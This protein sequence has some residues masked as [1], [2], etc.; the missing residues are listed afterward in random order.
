MWMVALLV[1]SDS[2]F[3]VSQGTLPTSGFRVTVDK[4]VLEFYTASWC[5]PCVAAKD[6]LA[7]AKDLPFTVKEIDVDRLDDFDGPIPQFRWSC[8]KSRA[9][10]AGRAVLTGWYGIEHLLNEYKRTNK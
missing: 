10:P 3:V 5:L 4:P 9:F 7:K 8:S 6:A 2:G 1:M